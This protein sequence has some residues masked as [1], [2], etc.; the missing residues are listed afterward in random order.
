MLSATAAIPASPRSLMQ[1]P[2]LFWLLVALSAVAL[3]PP[4]ELWATIDHLAVR[5]TDDA[6][7]LADVRALAAGQGWFDTVQHRFLP[8]DGVQSHWSR[9]VDAPLAAGFLALTPLVG[10]RLAE[11]L[12]AAFWPALLMGLYGIVLFRYLR[13]AFGL[14]AGILGVFAALNTFGLTVQFS[15][16]RV[17]HHNLQILA[18]LGASFGLMRPSLRAGLA[19]GALCAL[20]LAIGLEGLPYVVLAGLFLAVHW[21]RRGEAALKP[22]LG[23]G[24]GLGLAAPLLFGAQTSPALW[25]TSHCDALSPPW[26]WL[27]EGG[28]ATTLACAGLGGRLASPAARLALLAGLGLV[29]VAGF[30]AL[31]PACLS[32]P[33]SGMPAL[34]RE[35]WLLTVNEMTS[36]PAFIANRKWEA[37]VFYPP[38]M[39]AAVVALRGALVGAPERRR[40]FTVA[41]LCLWPGVAMGF[42]QLRGIYIAS[43]FIPLIAGPVMDRAIDLARDATVAAR[44]R[45]GTFLTAVGLVSAVWMAPALVAQAADPSSAENTGEASSCNAFA[46]VAPLAALPPGTVLGP[47]WIGPATLLY[48]PHS[49]IAAPYH[50]AIPGLVAAIEGLGGGEADL[51]RHVAERRADY[52]VVCPKEPQESLGEGPSFATRLG[53]GEVS[54]PWL[55]PIPLPGS[56]LKAWRV[57]PAAG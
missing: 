26:L 34:V 49:V 5:D 15:P 57:T 18:I 3:Y 22:F 37:F 8:P 19:S 41:S 40:H 30:A 25:G 42:F 31:F 33:F 44:R 38:L 14:R 47:I 7:R 29:L 23:F 52:I 28:L 24:L 20:S 53:R 48:T 39:I 51:R 12:T 45:Y 17:D 6:M 21:V 16:G 54:A 35:R 11:G 56:L 43:G 50:R 27:A 13:G 1:N 2:A 4:A 46:N 55:V 36:L 10:R 9:L 32:G